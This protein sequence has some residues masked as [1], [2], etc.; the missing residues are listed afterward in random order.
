MQLFIKRF[1][2]LCQVYGI[3]NLDAQFEEDLRLLVAEISRILFIIAEHNIPLSL[4]RSDKQIYFNDAE[5]YKSKRQKQKQKFVE[6]FLMSVE[7]EA[8]HLL[9]LA[10]ANMHVSTVINLEFIFPPQVP[11]DFYIVLRKLHKLFNLVIDDMDGVID[12]IIDKPFLFTY[13][14][15]V[16]ATEMLAL[17]GGLKYAVEPGQIINI[18][19]AILHIETKISTRRSSLQP[20][21]Y[22]NIISILREMQ[23]IPGYQQFSASTIIVPSD[24]R[25]ALMYSPNV[26]I[27]VPTIFML[28]IKLAHDQTVDEKDWE[29]LALEYN[30]HANTQILSYKI[31]NLCASLLNTI[32]H[33]AICLDL[34]QNGT[35]LSRVHRYYAQHDQVATAP[36]LSRPRSYSVP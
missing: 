9:D 27:L 5:F 34:E 3:G 33:R 11:V 14:A 18:G 13:D 29:Q 24:L 10:F 4:R 25:L 26:L 35:Y 17:I 21:I 2:K 32:E 8:V 1:K 19:A 15:R 20:M 31:S 36:T 12:K 28:I 7:A 6:D 16:D 30:K 22:K 23:E